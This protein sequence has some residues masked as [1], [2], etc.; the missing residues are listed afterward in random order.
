MLGPSTH[1]SPFSF[2]QE[3]SQLLCLSNTGGTNH[4]HSEGGVDREEGFVHHTWGSNLPPTHIVE[5]Q[6]LKRSFNQD[7]N[8]S[9]LKII[10]GYKSNS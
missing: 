7:K 4:S 6:R 8:K 5:L 9:K 10:E 2:L 3:D 1:Q